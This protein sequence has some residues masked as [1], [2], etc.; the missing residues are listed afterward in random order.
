[1]NEVDKLLYQAHIIINEATGKDI[2]KKTLDN[3]KAYARSIYKKIKVLDPAMYDILKQ[4]DNK[5]K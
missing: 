2:P 3:A 4:D 1:M 5:L